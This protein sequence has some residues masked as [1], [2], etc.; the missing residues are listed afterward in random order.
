MLLLT[1][2][3]PATFLYLMTHAFAASPALPRIKNSEPA[4]VKT[5]AKTLL[6]LSAFHPTVTALWD[7]QI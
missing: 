4:S 7:A 6:R 5:S 1:I 2:S 3:L